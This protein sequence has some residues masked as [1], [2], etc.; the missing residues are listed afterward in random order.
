M[1]AAIIGNIPAELI[2]EKPH[3]RYAGIKTNRL[4]TI[5][6]HAKIFSPARSLLICFM[7]SD[8]DGLPGKSQGGHVLLSDY[9]LGIPSSA[10]E[11]LVAPA[12]SYIQLVTDCHFF[13][14]ASASAPLIFI[15]TVPKSF[16]KA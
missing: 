6:S 9:G 13:R 10:G 4:Q 8:I 11:I 16:K 14:N 12:Y 3:I 7:A 1:A 15:D 5:I 2:D